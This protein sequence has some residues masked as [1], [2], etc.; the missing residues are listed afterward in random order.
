MARANRREFAAEIEATPGTAE[1]LVSADLLVRVRDGDA[2]NV[3]VDMFE[4]GEVQ[5]SSSFRPKLAGVKSVEATVS[6]VLRGPASQTV[7]PSV[8]D[9]IRSAMFIETAIT[10]SPIGAVTGGPFTDGEVVDGAGGAAAIVFRDTAT[11]ASE[12][13]YHTITS[14]PMGASEVLTGATSGATATTSGAAVSNG[15]RYKPADSNFGGSDTKHHVTGG[16]NIDGQQIVGNGM[17]SN[18]QMQFDVGRPCVVTQRLVGAQESHGDVALFSPATF[19]EQ[20]NVAPRFQLAALLLG[21]YSPSDI[22]GLTLNIET[23]PELRED[24]QLADG[25]LYAD[26]EKIAPLIT[27]EPSQDTVANWDPLLQLGAG[28][29][30]AVSWDCGTTAGLIWTFFADSCE[31]NT[32]E[33]GQERTLATTPVELQCSGTNNDEIIIWQH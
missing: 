29:S 33:N 20:T 2:W 11:G 5:A 4:T 3:N 7:A 21:S 14:G 9:L 8:S 16:F 18:L 17:L 6:Y 27:I 30:F 10:N 15:Q 28:T 1:T 24:A 22:R 12:L 32:V 26:Y 19:A 25:I 23:N 13:K 31:F